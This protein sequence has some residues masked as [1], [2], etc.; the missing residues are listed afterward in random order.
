[1][2]T[3]IIAAL[4]VVSCTILVSVNPENRYQEDARAKKVVEKKLDKTFRENHQQSTQ[5]ARYK[6]PYNG[7]IYEQPKRKGGKNDIFPPHLQ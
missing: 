3:F 5:L 6:N 4:L 1:M 2:F 7:I